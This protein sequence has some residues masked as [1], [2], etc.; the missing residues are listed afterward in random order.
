MK[1]RPYGDSAPGKQNDKVFGNVWIKDTNELHSTEKNLAGRYCGKLYNWLEI[2]M[3]GKA[4]LCCP[5]WLPYPIGNILDQSVDEIWNSEKAQE[6]RNQVFSGDWKYC[7]HKLCP[8]IVSDRLPYIDQIKNDPNLSAHEL[9]ALQNSSTYA[10][11]MPTKINFSNDESCNLKCPSCRTDKI[12]FTSGI[13]YKIRKK[14][15]DKIFEEFFSKPTDRKFEIFVT[16]SGDPFASKIFREMLFSIDGEQFPNLVINFQTNGVMFTSK[17]WSKL[18]RIHYN[19]SNC[20]ISFDAG[21]RYTYENKT[22]LGGHWNILLEN[23]DFLDNKQK[24]FPNFEIEY[25]FVVQADNYKEMKTFAT[26]ILE[27]YP[28][29]KHIN[30]T[31]VSDWGTWNEETYEKKCIWKQSH[32]EYTQFLEILK[33][34][35]FTNPKIN[36][37]NLRDLWLKANK[38]T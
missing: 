14:I 13:E 31:L 21:T 18:H 2:D 35:I 9:Q 12:L 25:D 30:F 34:P 29:A 19:L 17:M 26:L 27:R 6:L 16:G 36:L 5:S 20:K 24:Y 15:N 10:D 37:N 22:R 28:N 4:W 38:F 32:P 33:D 11:A 8:E 3:F 23:C 7:Q 1:E